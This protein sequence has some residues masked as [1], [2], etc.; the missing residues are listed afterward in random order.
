MIGSTESSWQDASDACLADDSQLASVTSQE[1]YDYLLNFHQNG[2]A[3]SK[4]YVYSYVKQMLSIGPAVDAWCYWRFIDG[5]FAK[6]LFSVTT[7]GLSYGLVWG[8]QSIP[9]AVVI[10]E[11]TMMNVRRV[12][13]SGR[14]ATGQIWP[15]WVQGGIIKSREGER[16]VRGWLTATGLVNTAIDNTNTFANEVNAN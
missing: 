16:P 1:E 9:A 8:T 3:I 6:S 14:G 5:L 4:I 2:W 15:L 10:M 11:K 12:A 13:T 7:E